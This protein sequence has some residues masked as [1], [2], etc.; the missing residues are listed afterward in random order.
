[1]LYST[2]VFILKIIK[3]IV[4]LLLTYHVITSLLDWDMS[5]DRNTKIKST[6]FFSSLLDWDMSTDN[7]QNHIKSEIHSA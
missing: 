7:I 5:T 1:M 3:I 2:R 6:L 4:N